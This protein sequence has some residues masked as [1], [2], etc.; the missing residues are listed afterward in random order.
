MAKKIFI[1]GVAIIMLFSLA[2]CEY[3]KPT[4]AAQSGAYFAVGKGSEFAVIYE[5]KLTLFWDSANNR[6]DVFQFSRDG[7]SYV[8]ENARAKVSIKFTGNNLTVCYTSADG[9]VNKK[10]KLK[11]NESIGLSD[12]APIQLDVPQDI[13]ASSSGLAWSFE[14]P[15]GS[16][17]LYQTG[18]LGVGV[19][20]KHP[21]AE[22]F[23]YSKILNYIPEPAC[24]FNVHFPDLN[25]IQGTNIIRIMHLGGPF[26]QNEKVRLSL[27]SEAVY[28]NVTID[29][30]GKAT[31]VEKIEQ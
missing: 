22:D 19:E 31:Q 13:S 11:Y 7:D 25:F 20:I 6:Y 9:F 4:E 3:S 21:D 17:A 29:A 14:P 16:N 15:I 27:N 1:L 18:V 23:A 12:D 8:G 28:F 5:N 24:F 10:I 2:A 26:V 30:E